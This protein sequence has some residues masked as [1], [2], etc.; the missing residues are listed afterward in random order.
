MAEGTRDYKRLESMLKELDLKREKNMAKVEGRLEKDLAQV[1]ATLEEIKALIN[2]MT[3]HHNDLHTQMENQEGVYNRGSILG[4]PMNKSVGVGMNGHSFRYATKLEFPKFNGEGVDEWFFKVEQF[5]VLEKTLEQFK[6]SIVAL[7]FE[8][9]AL[10][11]HRNF[12]KMKGRIPRWEEYIK[13][14]RIRFGPLT[15]E[16]LMTDLKK[17]KQ[18]GSLQDYM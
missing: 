18:T 16:D 12:L 15:Y 7:H 9:S 17:L 3:L 2:G 13:A 8:G 1:D 6:I 5:F 10:H 4:Q 11:W 14:L